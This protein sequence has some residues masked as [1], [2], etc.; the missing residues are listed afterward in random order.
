RPPVGRS[1]PRNSGHLSAGRP[2]R[3]GRWFSGAIDPELPTGRGADRPTDQVQDLNIPETSH[4]RGE[5]RGL[6]HLDWALAPRF[7]PCAHREE[8]TPTF[9]RPPPA[10]DG[11]LPGPADDR[12]HQGARLRCHFGGPRQRLALA[13]ELEWTPRAALAR[14]LS[15]WGQDCLPG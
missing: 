10:L 5:G 14:H 7:C 8:G 12:D 2:R 9:G 4:G 15:L 3:F 1:V 11:L 13:E 6:G